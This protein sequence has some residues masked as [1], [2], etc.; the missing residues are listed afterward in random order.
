MARYLTALFAA[1]M[2][3]PFPSGAASPRVRPA[4]LRI[5]VVLTTE[6]PAADLTLDTGT[7]L[8]GSAVSD[9]G[10]RVGAGGNHLSFTHDGGGPAEA[11]VRL[12]VSGLGADA[13]VR[14]HL[15]LSS[16]APTRL[17]VYNTNGQG[18]PT[19]VARF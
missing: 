18:R 12:L 5:G 14:W 19:L 11:H 15:T 13:R 6:S 2:A 7:I 3:L 17:E 1:L 8:N 4:L 10:L 9:G 16:Y